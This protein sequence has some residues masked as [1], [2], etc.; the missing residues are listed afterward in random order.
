MLLLMGVGG[1][2]GGDQYA[3]SKAVGDCGAVGER[4]GTDLG[5]ARCWH[6]MALTN[7]IHGIY[8]IYG[9]LDG[10]HW[11]NVRERSRRT[12]RRFCV[13]AIYPIVAAQ[14]YTEQRVSRQSAF[15]HLPLSDQSTV[16]GTFF[17]AYH[18]S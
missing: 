10:Q 1:V 14:S 9:I 5:L 17:Y 4:Q 2:V 13:V 7:G 6:G 3:V 15:T 12:S 16:R 8:G 11:M 18:E